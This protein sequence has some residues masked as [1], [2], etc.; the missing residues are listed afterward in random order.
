MLKQHWGHLKQKP[1][2]QDPKITRSSTKP[3]FLS[4]GQ[5]H[6]GEL[7]RISYPLITIYSSPLRTVRI[8]SHL[9]DTGYVF[10]IFYV[11]I[12]CLPGRCINLL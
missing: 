8:K 11:S 7:N 12:F 2:T 10:T 9:W 5:Y 4:D 3:G 1:L 6:F